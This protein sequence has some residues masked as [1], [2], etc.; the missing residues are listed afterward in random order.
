MGRASRKKVHLNKAKLEQSLAVQSEGTIRVSFVF[1]GKMYAHSHQLSGSEL[2]N[3]K[4]MLEDH[5]D[6]AAQQMVWRMCFKNAAIMAENVTAQAAR[7]YIATHFKHHSLG[8]TEVKP[9]TYEQMQLAQAEL[10]D[11]IG[12]FEVKQGEQ[13]G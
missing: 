5:G 1:A 6:D 3:M 4:Q 12:Q 2:K 11:A 7:D 10:Q 13:N 9:Q 8:S